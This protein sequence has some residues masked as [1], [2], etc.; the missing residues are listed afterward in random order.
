LKPFK[1]YKAIFFD[2]DGTAVLSRK[3]APDPVIAPMK[4]LLK[5]NI[6]L[7]II[8]G[9]TYDNIA[10][11]KLE[12]Y[13]S[14]DELQNL[15]LGLGRGA[16]NYRYD[17][18]GAPVIWEEVIPNKDALL[19]IHRVCF[20]IH[21]TLL[22]EYDIRTDIVFSRP[23]YC[24]IDLMVDNDRGDRLFLQGG[25]IETLKRLLKVHGVGGGLRE[26]IKISDTI[27]EAHGLKLSA[28]CD[29]KF[30]EV[31]LS[32]KS[33]NV[34][35]TLAMLERERGIKPEDCSFWGDEYIGVDEGLFGSDSFMITEKSKRG[36]FFDVSD[37]TGERPPGVARVGNGIEAF[38]DFLRGQ[39]H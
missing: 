2:W 19:K 30:L 21:Q 3:A 35:A 37:T 29:A 36:D 10:G 4:A 24:K 38:H 11:G 27:S 20:E 5:K 33:D 34:D 32:D 7:V 23:N 9:T 39:A 16:F 25:E 6:P 26:L 28:T 12:N 18:G 8:S 15:F 17:D 1:Q 22:K 31:G 13:F 14:A